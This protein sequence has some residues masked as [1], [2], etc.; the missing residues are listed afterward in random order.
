[1]N[2]ESRATW[3]IIVR[4]GDVLLCVTT[5]AIA[6]WNGKCGPVV[7]ISILMCWG[8]ELLKNDVDSRELCQM[9][10][11]WLQ[12]FFVGADLCVRPTNKRLN[13]C[14]LSM[15]GGHIGPPLHELQNTFDTAP[16]ETPQKHNSTSK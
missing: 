15:L 16:Y 5:L 12:S 10:I 1:M 2:L 6:F 14:Y 9:S 11:S 7:L 8:G 3:G 4:P 13:I